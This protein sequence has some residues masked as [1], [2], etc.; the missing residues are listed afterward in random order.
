MLSSNMPLLDVTE[1]YAELY[2]STSDK[3]LSFEE[4][5]CSVTE[6]AALK[7]YLMAY[8]SEAE[9]G[10]RPC[11]CMYH[12]DD[13]GCECY[14]TLKAARAALEPAPDHV[15]A[16]VAKSLSGV[17]PVLSHMAREALRARGVKVIPAHIDL[18]TAALLLAPLGNELAQDLLGTVLRDEPEPDSLRQ[19]EMMFQDR[20]YITLL[21]AALDAHPDHARAWDEAHD[22]DMYAVRAVSARLVDW[23]CTNHPMQVLRIERDLKIKLGKQGWHV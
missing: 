7:L 9:I 4:E 6:I 10:T 18:W 21:Y 17:A 23:F 22:Y 19:A 16:E 12:R 8:E 20:R 14:A 15:Q 3:K 13:R 1:R 2:I 11:E 5:G